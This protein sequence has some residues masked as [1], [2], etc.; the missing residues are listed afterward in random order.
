MLQLH[1]LTAMVP[2]F[3]QRKLHLRCL[4][5][6]D[7]YILCCIG[8]SGCAH[9]FAPRCKCCPVVDLPILGAG[10]RLEVIVEPRVVSVGVRTEL[11]MGSLPEVFCRNE[12]LLGACVKNQEVESLWLRVLSEGGERYC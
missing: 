4:D 5:T 11:H 3:Q 8:S 12:S 6:Y 1:R 2:F 9:I 10:Q 7:E